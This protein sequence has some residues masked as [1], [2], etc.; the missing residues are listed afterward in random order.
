MKNDSPSARFISGRCGAGM[1][2]GKA[3]RSPMVCKDATPHSVGAHALSAATAM[4]AKMM[5][6]SEPG[7]RL[8]ILGMKIQ[9]R[10]EKRPMPHAHQLTWKCWA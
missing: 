2:C 9:M 1:P 8:V 4:V 7:M 3:Y 6:A 10:S 5:A